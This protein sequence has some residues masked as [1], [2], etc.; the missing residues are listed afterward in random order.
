MLECRSVRV[1]KSAQE[2]KSV[3]NTFG[4][5]GSRS[6]RRT[7]RSSCGCEAMMVNFV[8]GKREAKG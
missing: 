4:V 8:L 6:S 1:K 3:R 5:P 7:A 2:C